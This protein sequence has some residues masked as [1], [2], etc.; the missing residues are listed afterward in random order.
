MT[1]PPDD[2]IYVPLDAC[3]VV[4][5]LIATVALI[6]GVIGGNFLAA[7]EFEERGYVIQGGGVD[8]VVVTVTPIFEE[9]RDE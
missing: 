8:K 3:L 9:W 4:G 1:T 2:D 6:L 5:V 7:R